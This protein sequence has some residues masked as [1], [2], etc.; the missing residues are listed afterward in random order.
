MERAILTCVQKERKI[1]YQ[2][3]IVISVTKI[4]ILL[5]KKSL[6]I[7][8]HATQTRNGL[9]LSI[10]KQSFSMIPIQ[11]LSLKANF[12]TY[13]TLQVIDRQ[14]IL[15]S[16]QYT[17][18]STPPFFS[19]LTLET[20]QPHQNV[21]SLFF[22]II[23][24]FED[25]ACFSSQV[26]IWTSLHPVSTDG[27]QWLSEAQRQRALILRHLVIKKLKDLLRMSNS[28]ISKPE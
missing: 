14:N 2:W 10:Y 6:F 20:Q 21:K 26:H 25:F 7:W 12:A 5:P 18:I 11:I 28:K 9:S 4:C 3:K 8:S 24:A 27:S 22:S 19:C 17:G 15:G 13:T 23:H 1:V 16:I